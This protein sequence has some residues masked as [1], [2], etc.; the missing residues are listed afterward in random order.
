MGEEDTTRQSREAVLADWTHLSSERFGDCYS[1]VCVTERA[2]AWN[3]IVAQAGDKPRLRACQQAARGEFLNEL[4][5]EVADVEHREGRSADD[6]KDMLERVCSYG[7]MQGMTDQQKGLMS[8]EI[9]LKLQQICDASAAVVQQAENNRRRLGTAFLVRPDLVLTA[10]HVVM[11]LVEK[12]GAKSW[13]EALMEDLAFEFKARSNQPRSAM[14]T[15]L[16]SKDAPLVASSLPYGETHQR[17]E[18]L[19]DATAGEKL[20]YALIRLAQRVDHVSPVDIDSAAPV[21]KDKLCWAFGFPGGN[22]LMMDVDLVTEVNEASGRWLHRANTDGGMSGGCCVNHEGAVAGIHEGALRLE[23]DGLKTVVNRGVRIDAIRKAQCRNGTDPLKAGLATPGVEFQDP[24][25]VSDFY[26]SGRRQGGPAAVEQWRGQVMDVF[27][28]IDPEGATPPPPFHPWFARKVVDEWID[29]DDPNERL[30]VIRGADGVGKSFC[31]RIMK[32]RIDPRLSDLVAF[33]PTQTNALDWADVVGR[34]ISTVPS[35]YRTAAASVR[36]RDFDEVLRELAQRS[37]VG[38]RT[39]NVVLDFGPPGDL[40]R[41]IGTRW[42]E[43]AA[44]LAA[45]DWIRVM[46]IGLDPSECDAMDNR[47]NARPE[48]SVVGR[49]EV[50]LHHIGRDELR[51]Y[52]K[53]LAT[54]RGKPVVEPDLQ[55]VL[56]EVSQRTLAGPESMR[57]VVAALEAIRFE[58]T[59]R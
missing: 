32:E 27:G 29:N 52:L 56:S 46:L 41:F 53:T 36:Y 43:F 31:A 48:T 49:R 59:L 16:A 42:V 54:A 47:M 15:V 10:A 24:A 58:A 35:Q 39:C 37:V 8:A 13:S 45:V 14:V 33:S 19:L 2:E 1:K 50:E 38:G 21:Q 23:R 11:G 55:K 20:D 18:T 6:I 12:D 17:L 25:L 57:T 34:I 5:R 4:A 44:T 7:V 9:L 22:S 40:G 30:C 26:L 28:G 51:T 3:V